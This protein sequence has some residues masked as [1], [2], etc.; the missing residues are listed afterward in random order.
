MESYTGYRLDVDPVWTHRKYKK[1]REDDITIDIYCLRHGGK[2]LIFYGTLE[3]LFC[4]TCEY[5]SLC[6][7]KDKEISPLVSLS[8]MEILKTAFRMGGYTGIIGCAEAF[9][10]KKIQ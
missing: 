1:I 4:D 2:Q 7:S 10:W 3:R 8:E 5:C 6:E 9:Q